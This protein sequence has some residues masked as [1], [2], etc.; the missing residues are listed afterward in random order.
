MEQF[1]SGWKRS[2]YGKGDV[3]A[4]RL[5]RD[6]VT[7]KMFINDLESRL[8]HRVQLTSDGHKPYLEAVCYAFGANVD[9]AMLVKMYGTPA[10]E[11]QRKYSSAQSV[12]CERHIMM[13]SPDPEHISKSFVERQN[14]PMRMSMRR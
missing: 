10:P 14:L 6:G 4:Y 2:Y 3:I 9:Y 1:A 11:D 5:N 7:A 13:G 8:S 12:G